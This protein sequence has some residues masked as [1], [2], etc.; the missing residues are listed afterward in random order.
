MLKPFDESSPPDTWQSAYRQAFRSS[1]ELNEFLGIEQDFDDKTFPIL[2][3]RELARRIKSG[4]SESPLWKQFVPQMDELDEMN[5]LPD[6]GLYDPIGDS[7]HSKG[8]GIIHRYKSRLLFSPTTVCPVNCR[9]CFRK[10][11]LGQKD[12]IL[13][14]KLSRLVSYLDANPEI[15]E[16]ILTGGDPLMLSNEKLRDIIDAVAVK[17]R[18]LRFHT[19]TPVILPERVDAGLISVLER[20]CQKFEVV[21]VAIHANHAQEFDKK[22]IDAI[23]RLG[24]SSVQLLSQSVLLKGVNDSLEDLK[25]LYQTFA[26]LKVRAYYLHHPDRVRGAMKFYLPL[27]EGRKLYARLRDELPGWAIPHYV[28]DPENGQG[29]NLAYNSETLEFSGQLLDRFNRAHRLDR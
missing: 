15:E 28:I 18:Y 25:S 29:K 20:A 17:A 8:H 3:P 16:V 12:D 22:R 27:I 13:K 11:E 10:N 5:G 19:R 21:S 9:Y 7:L 14:G 26:G 24:Q 2:V 6:E 23:Q 1:S 4:G